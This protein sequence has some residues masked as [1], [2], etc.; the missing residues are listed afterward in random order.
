MAYIVN[1]SRGEIVAVVQDGT[2][3]TTATSQT[4]VGKNVTPYGEFE[5]EN[6]VHQLENFANSTAP[7]NPL[8]GQFWYNTDEENMYIYTGSAWK[9]ASGLTVS[10]ETPILDPRV[11]DLWFDTEIGIVKIYAA[12]SSG[13]EWFPVSRV[14][15]STINPSD[16]VAGELYFN[17]A[18]KQ[19]FAYDG[20][21]WNLIGPEGV[22]NFAT[23]R[24]VS[25]TLLDTVSIAHAVML[26]QAN[27]VV[28]AIIA[29]ES[30]TI[31][32]GQRPTGFESLVPGINLAESARLAGRATGAERLD[33]G[34]L[35]NGVF[36]DGSTNITLPS[37]EELSAGTYLLGNPYS[38]VVA[39]TWSVDATSSNT[40]GK[41]VARD[42]QGDFSAG[43]ITANLVGSVSG[44][45]TNVTGIVASANGGTGFNTYTVGQILLGSSS[46][47]LTRGTIQGNNPITVT[48]DGSNITIGYTGGTGSGS[49]TSVGI[50]AGPGIGVSG[51]PVT[52]AGSITVNNTG[53][54]RLDAGGGIGV[55]RTNGNVTVTNTGVT[56]IIAGANITVSPSSGVGA[57]TVSASG[58]NGGGGGGGT[59]TSVGTGT[60]LTGG[61]IT[62]S[63]TISVD[64]TVVRTDEAQLI[65]TL[66]TFTGG[67]ISQSY[68][69]NNLSSIYLQGSNRVNIDINAVRALTLTTGLL[70]SSLHNQ[71][72]PF[73][74]NTYSFGRNA[75]RFTAIWA[76]NGTIQTS[77]RR[78]KTDIED[79]TLGLD[80]INALRPRRFRFRDSGNAVDPS[81]QD[82]TKVIKIPGQRWHH[83]LV[84][85]EVREQLADDTSF[86]GWILG[87]KQDPDSSQ[88]LRYDQFIAPLI[89]AVQELSKEVQQLKTQLQQNSPKSPG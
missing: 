45:A 12:T 15:V 48:S 2:I 34:C 64:E 23:T 78:D 65:S 73:A 89:R 74:D 39:Q 43:V 37:S 81:E 52:G 49:V 51:S 7:G 6:L 56:R 35:I 67:I 85:Q 71:W 83:G 5:V 61:P 19:L 69:F 79:T 57:V 38:G 20:V 84:A 53:V 26:G 77:D 62:S 17:T 63:G 59:V 70:G 80:F 18:T 88:G 86:A 30:F 3:N 54:T 36:F 47:Q 76:V 27:G 31:S 75:N 50:T 40:S 68:N 14:T 72:Y 9:P 28:Q 8:E 60:G 55:D 82:L 24:W 1:N 87:D 41:V 66:K 32:A 11:G 46:G 29:S 13:F 42:S 16:A 21:T 4:L 58:G 10:A 25:T 44:T 33:P 22:A